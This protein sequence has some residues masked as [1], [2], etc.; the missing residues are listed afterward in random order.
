M[1][2]CDLYLQLNESSIIENTIFV[3]RAAVK[4]LYELRGSTLRGQRLVKANTTVICLY[5]GPQMISCHESRAFKI[6]QRDYS[7]EHLRYQRETII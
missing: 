3:L 4:E 6:S 1:I 2:Y 7:V 5:M